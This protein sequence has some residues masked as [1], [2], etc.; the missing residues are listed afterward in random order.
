[1]DDPNLGEIVMA[2]MLGVS[3]FSVFT[4]FGVLLLQT[5]ETTPGA[6]YSSGDEEPSGSSL[7]FGGLGSAGLTAAP[8]HEL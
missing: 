4:P 8:Q 7:C 5:L 2:E 1:V 6:Q 3:P